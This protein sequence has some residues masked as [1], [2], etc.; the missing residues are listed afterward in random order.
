MSAFLVSRMAIVDG[1]KSKI[2]FDLELGFE[3]L[4]HSSAEDTLGR[5]TSVQANFSIISLDFSAV[6]VL[7]STEYGFSTREEDLLGLIGDSD[8]L[9]NC[10]KI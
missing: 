3:D 2:L 4:S 5:E 9:E 8:C 6:F 1:E 7:D 10:L